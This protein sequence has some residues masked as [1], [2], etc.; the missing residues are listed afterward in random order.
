MRVYTEVVDA[1]AHARF[2]WAYPRDSAGTMIDRLDA[3]YAHGYRERSRMLKSDA[4]RTRGGAS[5]RTQYSFER[6]TSTLLQCPRQDSN[7]RHTV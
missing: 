1:V 7:L 5:L 6:L 4:D 2:G 3:L